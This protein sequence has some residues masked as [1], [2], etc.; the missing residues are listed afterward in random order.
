MR[1][2]E[3]AFFTR[4]VAGEIVPGMATPTLPVSPVSASMPWTSAVTARRVA[5]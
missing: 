3:L 5:S 2:T 1:H 4:P